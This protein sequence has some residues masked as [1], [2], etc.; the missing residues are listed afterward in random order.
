MKAAMSNVQTRNRHS[1]RDLLCRFALC[2]MRMVD[3]MLEYH[4][5]VLDALL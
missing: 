4:H 5:L 2:R 1:R 3:P